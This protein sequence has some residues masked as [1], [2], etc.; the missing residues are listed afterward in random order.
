[1]R[2]CAL[3]YPDGRLL[4]TATGGSTSRCG[5]PREDSLM[6]V[7][8]YSELFAP[9]HCPPFWYYCS[10]MQ[11]H[12]GGQGVPFCEWRRAAG[13]AEGGKAGH[14]GAR[15]EWVQDGVLLRE[16]WHEEVA[17]FDAEAEAREGRK[18]INA[19]LRV[20]GDLWEEEQT[21]LVVDTVL[22]QRFGFSRGG[23][24]T[25][26]GFSATGRAGEG[27]SPH[28]AYC[29]EGGEERRGVSAGGAAGGERPCLRFEIRNEG[30]ARAALAE[31]EKRAQ[32]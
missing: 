13:R 3:F 4:G 9:S 26:E 18:Y 21:L 20:P 16:G 24:A 15:W 17:V 32:Q 2:K 8:R 14:A 30:D 12:V 23:S 19:R 11:R 7:E 31:C 10:Q 5:E 29:A 27:V 6:C 28:A 22:R 1:M 25:G